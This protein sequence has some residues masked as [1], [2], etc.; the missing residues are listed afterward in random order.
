M[1]NQKT[2]ILSN[3]IKYLIVSTH[4][5]TTSYIF[6]PAQPSPTHSVSGYLLRTNTHRDF[7]SKDA[8]DGKLEVYLLSR[9]GKE[10]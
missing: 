7:Y 4:K 1:A 5:H 10:F 2:K 3:W 6:F 8:S 9:E